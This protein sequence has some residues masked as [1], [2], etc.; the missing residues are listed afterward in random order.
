MNFAAARHS[1]ATL[2]EFG[3]LQ[4]AARPLT[5]PAGVVDPEIGEADLAAAHGGFSFEGF[6]HTM[7]PRSF[8]DQAEGERVRKI[9]VDGQS[10]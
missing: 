5:V 2:S 6:L 3:S 7:F 1:S 8:A 9:G 4:W 10:H